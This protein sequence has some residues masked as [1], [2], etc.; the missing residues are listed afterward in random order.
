M[1]KQN[2]PPIK[3]IYKEQNTQKSLN[4]N[5]C[6]KNDMVRDFCYFSQSIFLARQIFKIRKRVG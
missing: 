1:I 2:I 5:Q 4:N 6:F 3:E